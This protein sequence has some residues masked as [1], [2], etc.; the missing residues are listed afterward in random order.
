MIDIIIVA[1]NN[2]DLIVDNIKS[3]VLNTKSDFRLTVVNDSSSDDTSLELQK[4]K[5]FCRSEHLKQIIIINN[6]YPKFETKCENDAL[7]VA[8]SKY[9]ILLQADML[10][11]ENAFDLKLIRAM[12]KYNDLLL[13]SGRAGQ[14]LSDLK[15]P[16]FLTRGFQRLINKNIFKHYYARI[17]R[18]R[19]D[20]IQKKS[21]PLSHLIDIND[22]DFL[23]SGNI[24]KVGVN[25]EGQFKNQDLNG[26]KIYICS[27]VIRGPLIIDL[28]KFRKLGYFDQRHFFQGWDDHD[29]CIRGY[30]K[31]GWRVGFIPIQYFSDISPKKYTEFR[32]K[33]GS[34][35]N[36]LLI[37]M[38]IV[39]LSVIWRKSFLYQFFTEQMEI[40]PHEIREY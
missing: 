13:V 35:L 32:F 4:V 39:K 1:Y 5:E 38:K 11:R 6:R 27:S 20:S 25:I 29:V 22:L 3:V 10:I 33:K 23:E 8:K 31:F 15:E 40:G 34:V 19:H 17:I 14:N 21:K 18:T 26:N 36:E 30:V 12:E 2:E 24:G 28:E 37:F 7:K 16:F 9:A